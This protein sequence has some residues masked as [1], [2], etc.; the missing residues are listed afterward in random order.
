M[1]RV[2]IIG[3]GGSGKTTLARALAAAI[4]AP[5]VHLDAIYY[6]DEWNTVPAA[7]FA[8]VQD[9][10]VAE[11]RW[12]IDGNYSSSLAV[13]LAAADSVIVLDI[14]PLVCLWG[15]VKRRARF[16]GGQ[17]PTVGVYDRVTWGFVRYV[18]DYRRSTLP[19]VRRL[20][21]EHATHADVQIVRSHH[22]ALRLLD[23]L[24]GSAG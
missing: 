20:I 16:R 4:H 22:S 21:A 18:V 2:A 13:R 23:D 5:V 9:A 17:Y 24:H 15:I 6:D 7:T 19:R 14:H 3:C 1:D 8:R 10:L 12:V 11:P